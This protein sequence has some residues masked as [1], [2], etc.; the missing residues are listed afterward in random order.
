MIA[1]PN[2]SSPTSRPNPA[3]E[4]LLIEDNP[5]DI[6]LLEESL[7][8]VPIPTHVNT[9]EDGKTALE[10]L[11]HSGPYPDAPRPDLILLDLDLPKLDGR[12]LLRLIK[13][14]NELTRIPIFVLTGSQSIDD[15]HR[16]FA[17]HIRNYLAKP[18]DPLQLRDIIQAVQDFWL[19][20][21][22][23]PHGKPQ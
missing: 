18:V 2:L 3:V 11:R 19:S 21:E 7:K 9:V 14:D 15:V 12:E 22:K 10:F 16:A 23:S 5:G 17:L 6:R 20:S 4:I 1:S 13:A 8:E